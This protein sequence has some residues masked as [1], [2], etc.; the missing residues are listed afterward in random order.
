MQAADGMSRLSNLIE[1]PVCLNFQ[2]PFFPS[3]SLFHRPDSAQ[4]AAA[5]V[6]ALKFNSCIDNCPDHS[7]ESTPVLLP[8]NNLATRTHTDPA[9]NGITC[10]IRDVSRPGTCGGDRR[11]SQE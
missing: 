5:M 11:T 4:R 9:R 3:P 10:H 6:V 1:C 2:K 8:A 7:V